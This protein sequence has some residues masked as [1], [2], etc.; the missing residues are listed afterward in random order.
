MAEKDAEQLRCMAEEEIAS[1]PSV[2]DATSD[3]TADKRMLHEL[4]VH[5][6]EL[7][8]QNEDLRRTKRDLEESLA[9]LRK[10]IADTSAGYFLIDCKGNFQSVNEAWLRMHGYDS[11][12]EI[13]G[14]H[15]SLTQV[16]SDLEAA[17][18]NVVQLLSGH[19]IPAGEFSRRCKDGSVGHHTFSAN[20]VMENGAVVG[21]E[22]FLIDITERKRA[23]E[24]LNRF[25]DLV[26]DMVC[27]ASTDGFFRKINKEWAVALDFSQEELL[28]MP[29]TDL[30]HPDDINITMA[31]VE[32]QLAGES[33]KEFVNRYRCKDGTYRWLEWVSTPAVDKTFL[34][35]AA[36]DV[37]ERK[38]AE[39]QIRRNEA[40]LKSIVN[41]L[42]YRAATIQEFLD[43]ALNEAIILTESKI[44]YIYFY[45]EESKHFVL[46]SWSKDVMKEC[47]IANPETCYALDKTGIW[48]EAVRQRKTIILN[49]FPAE[50]PL[51]K[52][53]PEGHAPLTKYMTVP[54]FDKEQIV[55]V[56]GVANKASAYDETDVL[57]L[58]LLMDAVWKF[59]DIKKGEEAL[60]ES[61]ARYRRITEGLT[62]YLYSV[63]IENG[64]AVETIQSPACE[65]VTG[66][67]PQE[68]TDDPYLWIKMVLPEDR[69][70]VEMRV[71]QLLEGV[72]VP[73]IEHR[74]IRKDGEVRWVRDSIIQLKDSTGNL[75]SYD[76]VIKDITE[77]KRV[78]EE[79]V[80]LE[81]QLHQAQKMESV[82][83]LAGGVAHD[84]NNL[85]TVILG[86]AHL[87]L[88]DS[89]PTHPHHEFLTSIKNAAEK[90]AELTQQL[91]AFARKQTIAPKVL[92]LN[93][94]VA[95]MLKMLQRLIGE[96]I[97][98]TLQPGAKLWLI[99]ADPSQID[100]ILANLCVNARD[101]I[102]DIGKI[103]I[104]TG[105]SVLDEQYCINHVGSLPGEYI[106]LD[107][108]DSG[109]GMDKETLGHIFEP[110]FTTKEMGR[111]TG[112]GLATVFGAVKQNDGFIEVNSEPGSGT[113]F[114]IYLPRYADKN[115]KV[116]KESQAEA[117]PRGNETI[118]VVEDEAAILNITTILLTKLGYAVIAAHTPTEALRLA[119]LHTGKISLLLTDVVMPE[120]NGIDLSKKLES[121]YPDIK[122]I[123][124]S[125]YTADI[126]ARHGVLNEG[127]HFIKKPYSMPDLATKVREV[128]DYVTME[129]T[130]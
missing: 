115:E 5:K 76:G 122:T 84:F 41:I 51:K 128:L 117:A 120:E 94:T 24:D 10:I 111:G 74:I 101:S 16:E 123:F 104:E 72:D 43:N 7:E 85:L 105:N 87:V 40:R 82:G 36:R 73:F 4:H 88:A 63:R 99:K 60:L 3:G 65:K 67:K 2:S 93:E 113:T 90:S 103:T 75:L 22:G 81:D 21:L 25:F 78:K 107:V 42:Q 62:D 56:V 130:P 118:L 77:S 26:P 20:P 15:F 11:S 17:Q 33:T 19:P 100:Q 96:D 66:Y 71:R 70:L 95:N 112:L 127:I 68:F 106:R 29:F 6:I 108:S 39:D 98:L 54:I 110:F 14:R 86:C 79:R 37:T 47:R 46:N 31:E 50:H 89:D 83:R 57:Q 59:V 124:M 102:T 121:L 91:L 126:I 58:T 116:P 9:R 61:E 27:I 12:E 64:L 52:G 32:K 34:Y 55:A 35:A 125:G 129:V 49:D 13:I 109:S 97:T 119:Q 44:G 1:Q 28:A 48:G 8:M 114:T 80:K 38:L 23:E 18:Q 53:Y 45:H 30:I 69:E 92:D